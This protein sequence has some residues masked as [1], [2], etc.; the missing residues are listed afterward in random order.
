MWETT[1]TIEINLKISGLTKEKSR[2]VTDHGGGGGGRRGGAGGWRGDPNVRKLI[3]LWRSIDVGMIAN[4]LGVFKK[5]KN[6]EKEQLWCPV[7]ILFLFLFYIFLFLSTMRCRR[8]AVGWRR[9]KK[10][11][12]KLKKWSVTTR[13]VGFAKIDI[14]KKLKRMAVEIIK[15]SWDNIY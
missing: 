6:K 4:R 3:Q 2:Q 12:M 7:F 8:L 1:H 15:N 5:R 9:D 11:R 13:L 14:I 10:G